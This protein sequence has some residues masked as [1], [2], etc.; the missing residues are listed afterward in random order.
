[1]SDELTATEIRKK[2][3]EVL[4]HSS[5]D[6]A[7]SKD[8]VNWATSA[9]FANLDED[10]F[11]L[12]LILE[13]RGRTLDQLRANPNVGVKVV[14]GGIADPFAQ[15][16]GTV[17]LRDDSERDETFQALLRKEPQV[18]PFFASPVT[19][20]VIDIDWWRVTHLGGGWLPGK[21]LERGN[22]A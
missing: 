20:V 14:P 1:M 17:T 7:T 4:T 18:E 6:L 2:L 16:L 22:G 15:G 3:T 10:L 11:R 12:T 9:F 21:V 8:G 5:I 13:N 19:A